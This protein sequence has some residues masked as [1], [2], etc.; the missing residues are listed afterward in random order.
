MSQ[1]IGPLVQLA[2]GQFLFFEDHCNG[3]GRA[4]H[5]LLEQLM[6]ALV[7][8]IRLRRVV[9]LHQQLMT[10]RFRQQAAVR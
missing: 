1:L 7:A 8:R 4:L 3:I 5:L 10:F 9:P 2:I 6:H